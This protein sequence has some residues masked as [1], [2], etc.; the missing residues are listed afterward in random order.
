MSISRPSRRRSG[1][2]RSPPKA[3]RI[4]ASSSSS[5]RNSRRVVR[6]RPGVLIVEHRLGF[7]MANAGIDRSNVDPGAGAEPVL[8]LPRDPDG[9][10]ER[11]R[12]RLGAR[13]GTAPAVIVADSFGRAW[14]R[15]TVGDRAGRGGPAG[16]DR[17]CAAGPISMA[18]RCASARPGFAD[19]IAAAASLL[20]GQ[21]D[22]GQPAI[23]VRGLSWSAADDARRERWCGPN[24]R[25]CS[26]ERRPGRR[27]V[28]RRRRRQARARPRP[29]AAARTA[30]GGRQ[31]RR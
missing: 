24:P 14:R 31:Y 19:E 13:F 30:H 2:A 20:M 27:A 9:S 10:A 25:I 26:G 5:S 7:V 12:Q 1:R 18:A 21:A 16:D 17:I 4:R 11:L 22:E 6:R 28:G 29:R 23:V 15:G 3:T 8:L